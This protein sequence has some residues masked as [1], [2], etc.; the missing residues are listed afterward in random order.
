MINKLYKAL[1]NNP[2]SELAVDLPEAAVLLPI[3]DHPRNPEI[4]F[5]LRAA[6]LSTHSGE[7]AFPGGKRDESDQSLWF[8]A[9]RESYEEINLTA[10]HVTPLGRLNPLASR[11]GLKVVPFV[12]L[13][14]SQV[15]LTPNLDE[16]DLIFR[17]PLAFFL[18]PRHL[19][20]DQIEFFGEFYQIPYFCYE[21][22]KIWG[23]TALM[24]VDLLNI[25]FDA[26]ISCDW[27]QRDPEIIDK[28]VSMKNK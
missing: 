28:F 18:E 26:D 12:G 22:F 17:A 15:A 16:L 8:T 24:L 19:K 4:I 27:P 23:L 20:F 25:G 7:V 14:P 2:E 11:F 21:Q 10:D 13:I 1:T 6:H 3:T 5:T 9:L